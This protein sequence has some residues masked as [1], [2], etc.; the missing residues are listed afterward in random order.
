MM[1]EFC[2]KIVL[3]PKFVKVDTKVDTNSSLITLK[4]SMHI[5]L[6]NFN[7]NLALI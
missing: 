4:V 2:P 7:T 1:I 5:F 6:W 3:I